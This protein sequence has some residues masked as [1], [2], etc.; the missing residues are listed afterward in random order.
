[1][2]HRQITAIG[3]KVLKEPKIQEICATAD[4]FCDP[5]SRRIYVDT[6]CGKRKLPDS[7]NERE[8]EPT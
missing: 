2:R 5:R 4:H 6:K 7:T 3:F 1:M 8:V